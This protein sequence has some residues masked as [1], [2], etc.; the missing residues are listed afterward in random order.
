LDRIVLTS[1][2]IF[3]IGVVASEMLNRKLIF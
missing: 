3:A 1:N 2:D